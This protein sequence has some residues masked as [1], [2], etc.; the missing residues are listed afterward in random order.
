M[1]HEHGAD[2]AE[3]PSDLLYV[4]IALI[5]AFLTALEVGTYFFEETR[6]RGTCVV[7]LFPMMIIK[8]GTVILYFMH[9]KYDNPLFKRVFLFGLILAVV[10]FCIMLTTFEF[11][12]DDY[13]KFLP[14]E[15]TSCSRRPTSGGGCRTRRCGSSSSASSVLYAYAARV[16]GPKVGPAGHAAGHPRPAALV[17]AGHRAA[18]GG[19]RLAG[20]RHRRAVPLLRAHV[21][22]HRAH[23]RGAAGDAARHPRVAG[24]P[25]GRARAGRRDRPPAGPAGPRRPSPSTASRCCRTGR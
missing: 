11:W 8:F 3:H 6:D 24:P 22:A 16:I 13:L 18:V 2:H 20:A 19:G 25:R 23:A 15:L 9:L 14:R 4:K 5:L 10:V 12:D 21:A 7:I 17:R 1:D